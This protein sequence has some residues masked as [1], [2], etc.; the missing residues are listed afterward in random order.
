MTEDD[1]RVA[2]RLALP[3]RRRRDPFDAPGLDEEQL[4]A[5]A[6]RRRAA[7]GR[8]PPPDDG[9]DGGGPRRRPTAAAARTP[10]PRRRTHE[11]PRPS[12][13][14]GGGARPRRRDG[15][16][17]PAPDRAAGRAG[18]PFRA[19]RL[20]GRRARRGRGRDA[21]RAP[22]ER[23][24]RRRRPPSAAGAV[25]AAAPGRHAARRRAA[26]ARPR[27]QRPGA[28]CCARDDLREA[29]ARGP[30]GQPRAVR[31][32]R[33]RL[34]GR[35]AR[36]W[37]R[38]RARSL[39]P[40]ARR[41]PAPR[42]GRPGDLPRRGRPSWRC[43]RP[44]GGGRPR[45]RLDRAAHRRPD[46]AGRRP[47]AGRTRCCA[48]SGCATRSAGRCSSSSPTAGP[49]PA[50]GDPAGAPRPAARRDRVPAVV[51]DCESGPVRLGLAGAARR[52]ALARR[53]L[54]LEELRAPTRSPASCGP[55]RTTERR[56][57]MP[58]GQPA[59]V[60]DDGLTTRQRR[61]RPLLVV[62]TGE[63][64][65]K[66]TAA[67]GL[68]LRGWNQ[69]WSIGVFQFVK[70]AK[71]KVGEETA[72]RALGRLHDADRRGRPGRLAQDGRGLVAGPAS[73][74]PTRT[75]PPTRAEGW[76]RDQARPRRRGAPLLR[77]R[78]VH[79]PDEVGLGGRR[80]GRRDAARPARAT[81]T[82]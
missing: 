69:G 52:A 47:A 58:Q 56:G 79:L 78:R 81:S 34:D 73:R 32:R 41:L 60:P 63:M 65:G 2:A 40:A 66:S 43:R 9:P 23:G 68:A 72:F 55:D 62:H 77:A 50:G 67:F 26:P 16:G 1:V 54:R 17:A 13:G 33:L 15:H 21:A 8:R 14:P 80:R 28:A 70:S 48:S 49:P 22:V 38:S 75:T 20:R 27:P 57:L 82:S 10:P 6:G 39:S 51:V 24:R 74:A 53:A 46:A 59:T 35:R 19:R 25:H 7:R 3:H 36:G 71:W 29:G 30:R 5:G 37:P 76:A 42:Q 4:D 31:R 18:D 11:R 64:K 12:D 61:N 44:V 45:A